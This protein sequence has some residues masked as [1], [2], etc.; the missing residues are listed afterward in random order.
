MSPRKQ[1]PEELS[2]EKI[3]DVAHELFV[4]KGY[5]HVSMR[6][7]AKELNYSHGS[8]YYHFKN[9]ADL[10]YAMVVKDFHM[11]N[12]VLLRIMEQELNTV[13]KL[14]AIL[15]GYI[16]FGLENKS[17]YELMFLINDEEVKSCIQT[18]P[19]ESYEMFANSISQLTNN[20]ISIQDIWSIFLSLHGFV[21]H[22]CRSDQTYMEVKQLAKLHVEYIV[23]PILV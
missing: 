14:K 1:V 23:K 5:Q 22:Y 6:Q 2:R 12:G 21:T 13:E 10:F 19:L 17:H 9:K 20:K 3:M 11:L 4:Q 18:E 16:E 8:I 7:I 15:L